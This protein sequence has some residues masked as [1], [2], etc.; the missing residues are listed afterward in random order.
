MT[1]KTR[2]EHLREWVCSKG[3]NY[4]TEELLAAL[5]D[6]DIIYDKS[7]EQFMAESGEI[8]PDN[9]LIDYLLKRNIPA[10]SEPSSPASG[11]VYGRPRGGVQGVEFLADDRVELERML[12]PEVTG[13]HA[14]EPV[15]GVHHMDFG[16]VS[17]APLKNPFDNPVFAQ[18]GLRL[19]F[20]A[21]LTRAQEAYGAGDFQEAERTLGGLAETHKKDFAGN[22]LQFLNDVRAALTQRIPTEPPTGS[23]L[24]SLFTA[25]LRDSRAGTFSDRL[26][27]AQIHHQQGDMRFAFDVVSGLAAE[28]TVLFSDGGALDQ[29]YMA[30]ERQQGREL[31]PEEVAVVLQ[32]VAF[33]Y[34]APAAAASLV[35]AAEAPIGP[36]ARVPAMNPSVLFSRARTEEGL[37][38]YMSGLD[39]A[40]DLYQ[41]GEYQR[42]SGR[43]TRVLEQVQAHARREDGALSPDLEE[44]LSTLSRTLGAEAQR[45]RP[46]RAAADAEQRA[47]TAY[48]RLADVLHVEGRPITGAELDS[49]LYALHGIRVEYNPQREVFTFHH[50]LSGEVDDI[51][52]VDL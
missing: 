3:K 25:A 21:Y 45:A 51:L 46:E 1:D 24:D 48:D 5:K 10:T 38:G 39:A 43:V 15:T 4:S 35:A 2:L 28:E 37:A 6:A 22:E 32:P 30:L 11:G 8:D 49:D 17:P 13:V 31:L 16:A 36:V 7:T 14:V 29:L 27:Q 12:G 9:A 40:Y 26:T 19:P 20:R 33:G 50:E 52:A 47:E 18:L 44:L 41:Q 23:P 34:R 42:A